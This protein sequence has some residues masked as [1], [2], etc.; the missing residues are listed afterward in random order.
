[1]KYEVQA[2]RNADVGSGMSRVWTD[3]VTVHLTRHRL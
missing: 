2:A 3:Q 1:M